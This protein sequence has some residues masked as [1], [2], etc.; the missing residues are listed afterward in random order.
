M[1]KFALKIAVVAA[2]LDSGVATAANQLNFIRGADRLSEEVYDLHVLMMWIITLIF[3]VV[4][5]VIVYSVYKH[6]KSVDRKA[7]NFHANTSVEIA[8]TVAPFFILL[9]MTV[10]ASMTLIEER[11]GSS[12][13]MAVKVSADQGMGD[14][15][16]PKSEGQGV[17][18]IVNVLSPREQIHV[19]QFKGEIAGNTLDRF[20]RQ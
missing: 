13:V 20:E 16:H 7:A 18:L 14:H 15:E 4:F 12:A 19:S 1:G 8:W 3:C 10:P 6:R 9:A 2:A 5:G 11:D 17:A